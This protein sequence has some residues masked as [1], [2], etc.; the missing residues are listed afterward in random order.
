MERAAFAIFRSRQAAEEAK[1]ALVREGLPEDLADV[2]PRQRELPRPPAVRHFYV[3]YGVPLVIL[4][5]ASAGLLLA[6]W[7]GLLLGLMFA[8]LYGTLAAVLSGKIDVAPA[9]DKLVSKDRARRTMLVVDIAGA[10]RAGIDYKR[11]LVEHGAV[12]VGMT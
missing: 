7:W 8:A 12:R 1:Q 5:G 11:F 3:R 2:Q 9:V 10:K 4:V 6:G